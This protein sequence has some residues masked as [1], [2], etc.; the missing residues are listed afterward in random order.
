MTTIHF[1]TVPTGNQW[2]QLNAV[3][4]GN[5]RNKR[6][7]WFDDMFTGSPLL[8]LGNIRIAIMDQKNRLFCGYPL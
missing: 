5:E 3:Q 2:Q 4:L 8:S 6:N 7:P 1:E